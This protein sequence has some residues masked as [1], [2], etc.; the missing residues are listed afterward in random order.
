MV[1]PPR[2]GKTVGVPLGVRTDRRNVE[3]A[4]QGTV[5]PVEIRFWVNS[6]TGLQLVR[7]LLSGLSERV[8]PVSDVGA[9]DLRDGS[10][11][12]RLRF[13]VVSEQ[14]R[15]IVDSVEET[16]PAIV[17][18]AVL[19]DLFGRVVPANLVWLG[20]MLGVRVTALL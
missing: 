3:V 20:K 9:G 12:L 5:P 15:Q 19:S 1:L 2:S 6:A 4:T 18:S 17:A 16:D 11:E 13:V 10:A 8:E 14:L 7:V